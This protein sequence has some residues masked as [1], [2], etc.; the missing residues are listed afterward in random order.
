MRIWFNKTFSSIHAVLGNLRLADS[1]KNITLIFSH[2]HSH[3][4]GFA[5]ADESYLEPSDLDHDDYLEWLL[6]FCR[7]RNIDL[8]WPGKAAML[9]ASNK[10]RFLRAGVNLVSVADAGILELLN[11]KAEFHR[12]LDQK[13]AEMP[14]SI[15]VNTHEEFDRA[16]EILRLKHSRICVKPAIS[17][18]GLGFRIIDEHRPGISHLLS[19]REH[20]ISLNELRLGMRQMEFFD[21]LLVME[22]L[23]GHEWSVDCVAKDG[24]LRHAVQRRKPLQAGHS[25]TFD[26]NPEIAGMTDRLTRNYRLNGL[27]NIQ[28]KAGAGGPKLLEIN[29]RPSGGIGMAC[30]SGVNLAEAALRIFQKSGTNQLSPPETIAYGGNVSEINTPVII[31]PI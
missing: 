17:V 1:E 22:Y 16:F 21:T 26:N 6:E 12:T 31:Q 13:I 9:V 24:D 11:N 3:A 18:F 8:F 28:F 2:E 29:P 30:M 15:A 7:L 14:D 10:Q 19:G 20:H 25:Q 4:P 23:P 5:M 27:F